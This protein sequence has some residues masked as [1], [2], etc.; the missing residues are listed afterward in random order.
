MATLSLTV[1]PLAPINRPFEHQ[2]EKGEEKMRTDSS[3]PPKYEVSVKTHDG[4][5]ENIIFVS[6]Y[7]ILN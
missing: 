7:H 1:Q 2:A 4:L 6:I 5:A 3:I